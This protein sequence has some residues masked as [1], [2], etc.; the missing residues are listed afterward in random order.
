MD[1]KDLIFE[2]HSHGKT[3][4]PFLQAINGSKL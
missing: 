4:Q 1:V 2:F 3:L